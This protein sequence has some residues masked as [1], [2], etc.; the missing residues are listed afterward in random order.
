VRYGSH[1]AS[2][3]LAAFET[4][5]AGEIRDALARNFDRGLAEDA[6]LR[7]RERLFLVAEDDTPRLA[8]YAGRGDLE[9]WLRAAAVRTAIDLMRARR[10]VAVADPG[11]V[12]EATVAS[13][14]LL[15]ALKDHY[16]EEFGVAFRET[17]ATLGD[18]DRT[19]LRYTYAEGL[20][21]DEIATLCRVHRATAAR[22]VAA[23]REALFDTTRAGLMQRLEPPASDVDSVLRLIDSQLDVSLRGVLRP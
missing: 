17:L 5:Y 10:E 1:A 16:R 18:R 6:E 2:N 11:A 13:D 12:V 19:L 22:W 8:S 23:I 21:I 9:A 4:R 3:A 15:A 7:L 14:P 20:T